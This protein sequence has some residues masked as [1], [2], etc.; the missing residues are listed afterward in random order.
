MNKFLGVSLAVVL[1][2][3]AQPPPQVPPAPPPPIIAPGQCNDAA[4][5]FALGRTADL[6][7][8]EEVRARAGVQRVRLV[9]PGQMVTM[10]FDAARL[11]LDVDAAD[12]VVRARCG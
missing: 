3:C 12:K 8:V 4:A 6:A 5:Q 7:L 10:E 9:R 1:A 2:G 11:T